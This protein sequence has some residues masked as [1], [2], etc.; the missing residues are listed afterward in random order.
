M[1]AP[2]TFSLVHLSLLLSFSSKPEARDILL[3][4]KFNL[5]FSEVYMVSEVKMI[6]FNLCICVLCLYE[7]L[8]NI[9]TQCFWKSEENMGFLGLLAAIV[10]G[11]CK[12]PDMGPGNQTPA[13]SKSCRHSLQPLELSL[14]TLRKSRTFRTAWAFVLPFV[15]LFTCWRG[16]GAQAGQPTKQSLSTLPSQLLS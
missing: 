13:L 12:L 7:F 9:C 14:T 11:G 10:I 1:Q 16:A 3:K 4:Y 5:Y 6:I 8:C 15:P 2:V